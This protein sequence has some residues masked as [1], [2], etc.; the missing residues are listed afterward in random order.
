MR[1]VDRLRL[2][3]A[4]VVLLIP[5]LVLA[6]N[7]LISYR[8][9]GFVETWDLPGAVAFAV[10]ALLVA[11]GWRSALFAA[12][13][14]CAAYLVTV[15]ASGTIPFVLY[16]IVALVALGQAIPVAQR[17]VTNRVKQLARGE[18]G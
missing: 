3:L 1:A 9:R 11:G 13:A 7:A 2:A 18:R 10:L 14:L 17:S 15:V 8:E 16:W 6:L 4:A 12:L 5:A